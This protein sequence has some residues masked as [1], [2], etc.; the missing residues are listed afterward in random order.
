M[1][2]GNNSLLLIILRK[3]RSQT[4]N[5]LLDSIL[6]F[7][8]LAHIAVHPNPINRLNKNLSAI[9]LEFAIFRSIFETFCF[10]AHLKYFEL[11]SI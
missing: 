3:Y 11:A 9:F 6:I 4:P 10:L 8:S 7:P 2:K 1:E 5:N